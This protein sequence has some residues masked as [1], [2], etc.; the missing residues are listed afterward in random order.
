MKRLIIGFDLQLF[1]RAADVIEA[2]RIAGGSDPEM[3]DVL[4][5][6]RERG[7]RGR[8]L[9]MG[10]WETAGYLQPDLSL[11]EAVDV[12]LTMSTP[13]NYRYMVEEAGWPIERYEEWLRQILREMLLVEDARS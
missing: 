5:R 13:D 1:E 3:N 7:R 4:R 6:G 12:F 2:A 9:V 10:D 11:K 8:E